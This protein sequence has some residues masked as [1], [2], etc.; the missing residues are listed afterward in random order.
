[1]NALRPGMP[2]LPARMAALPI[3]DRGFPVPFFVAYVNGKPDHRISDPA[4]KHICMKHARCWLCGQPLGRELVFTI[5]PMCMVNRVSSEPPQHRECAEFAARACPFLSRPHAKR[6]EAGVPECVRTAPGEG[7]RRN[8]GV[9][10]VYEAS[11]FKPWL[12]DNG[13]LFRLGEPVKLS[14]FAEGRQATRDEV[15]E[16]IRT[17]LPLL[18][19][20]VARQEADEGPFCGARGELFRQSALAKLLLDEFLPRAA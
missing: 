9:T 12:V 5:G 10:L 16:A 19:E 4:K 17:G 20:A 8:P 6:R 13:Y 11:S 2:T 1:M 3:D 7:L 18:E 15:D 14:F